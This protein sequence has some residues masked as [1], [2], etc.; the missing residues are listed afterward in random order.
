MTHEML[1]QGMGTGHTCVACAAA[2]AL[3]AWH[4]IFQLLVQVQTETPGNRNFAQA[5]AAESCTN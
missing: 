2:G 1:T 4:R 3:R 5:V